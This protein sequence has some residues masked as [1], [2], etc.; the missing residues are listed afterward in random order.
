MLFFLD[1]SCTDLVVS[2]PSTIIFMLSRDSDRVFPVPI[3]IPNLN[4]R[5]DDIPELIDYFITICCKNLDMPPIK[6][7]KEGYNYLQS[8]KIEAI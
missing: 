5:I 7:S 8:K 2:T 6:L 3:K 4:D 1:I